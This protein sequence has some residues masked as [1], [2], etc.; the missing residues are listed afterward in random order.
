MF[1]VVENQH[2]LGKKMASC[3]QKQLNYKEIAETYSKVNDF[4]VWLGKMLVDTLGIALGDKVLDV[5]C[6]TGE[7]TAY[8]ADTVKEDGLCV[9]FDPDK[10]R[11][12]VA[13]EKH[14]P[15]RPNIT[16]YHGDSSS[17]FPRANEEFY[18][19]VFCSSVFHWMSESEKIVFLKTANLS[20]RPGGKLVILSSDKILE[21]V[22]FTQQLVADV[23]TKSDRP[24]MK[25]FKK[26]DAEEMLRINGF[27]IQSSR[28]F[29]CA[30]QFKSLDF[31]LTWYRATY[32]KEKPNLSPEKIEKFAK[33]FQNK[34][35]TI[36]FDGLGYDIIATKPDES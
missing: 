27:V 3:L 5:G 2:K 32:Y 9:G 6:G 22:K 33:Q 18:D 34:D 23:D 36:S 16:F 7:I 31:Y 1:I 17:E 25:L 15:G 29:P 13:I 12:E 11:I 10:Y 26:Q 24:P 28:Y 20:L 19:Y 4:Q 14:L 8:I 21:I 35:G 30:Y